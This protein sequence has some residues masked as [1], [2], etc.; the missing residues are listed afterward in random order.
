MG[1]FPAEGEGKISVKS[2]LML[3]GSTTS[4]VEEAR[5]GPPGHERNIAARNDLPGMAIPEGYKRVALNH[6][7]GP[8]EFSPYR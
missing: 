3:V 6:Q 4:E 7:A 5:S 2:R 1:I 8:S